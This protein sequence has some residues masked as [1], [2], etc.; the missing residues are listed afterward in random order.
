MLLTYRPSIKH[1]LNNNLLKIYAQNYTHFKGEIK[2]T[3]NFLQNNICVQFMQI[4]VHALF[5]NPIQ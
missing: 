4:Y 5:F 2:I 1:Y 3:P